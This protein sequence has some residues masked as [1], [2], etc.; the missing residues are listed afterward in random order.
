MPQRPRSFS[1][2]AEIRDFLA[3]A[4]ERFVN[5]RCSQVA[6]TLT[7][8]SLLGFVPLMALILAIVT[9]FPVFA[10]LRTDLESAL[11]DV[12]LPDSVAM[13]E[14]HI[15]HFADNAGRLTAVGIV[16]LALVAV[17]L[18]STIEGAFN[19]IWRIREKRPV[20]V[21][22]VTF[23]AML[24][25]GPILFGLSLSISSSL[26]AAARATGVESYT[27]PLAELAK[28]S[29][30][31]LGMVGFTILYFAMPNQPVRWLHAVIG[32]MTA[33]VGF[34]LLKR[35][36][37]M[38]ITHF[39]TYEAIYGAL[40]AIPIILVWTYCA[41][42]VVL[43]GAVITASLPD[44]RFRRRQG[45]LVVVTP[46]ERLT[47]ALAFLTV[48]RNGHRAGRD[49]KRSKL[50]DAVN[51]AADLEEAVLTR[52]VARRLVVRLGRA[53][54]RLGQ[55]LAVISVHDLCVALD[56][57][58]FSSSLSIGVT[59]TWREG[60]AELLQQVDHGAHHV[61]NVSIEQVLSM[62]PD[63]EGIPAVALATNRA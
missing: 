48:L 50:L 61:L 46:G 1:S 42:M 47:V 51:A 53:R 32:G 15:D 36:F 40:A 45:T 38:F 6:A 27:G 21:R 25:M 30:P 8:T 60:L 31:L 20:A 23:W 58:P 37:G 13:V 59:G 3:Y 26:F 7:Y 5:D 63:P 11:F 54:F 41:W 34:E 16:G 4:I 55:D 35:G 12:F 18:L 19:Q 57:L 22:L 52:L 2:I 44:W 39:P 49:I 56:L 29:A 9:A 10:G 24:T 17:L 43:L 33:T 28:L 62:A 14:E